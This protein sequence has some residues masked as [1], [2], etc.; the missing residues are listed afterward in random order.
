MKAIDYLVNEHEEIILFTDRLEEEC[1]K[2]MEDKLIDEKFFRAAIRYIREF[3][4]GVHHK[5]EED[6]LFKYMVESL[7]PAAEKLV[8]NGMLVEHQMARAYCMELEK[9][10]ESYL[11]SKDNRDLLQVITNTMSYVNLLRQHADK[12][13]KVVYPFAQ[14]HLSNEIKDKIEIESFDLVEI[15]K[16]LMPMKEELKKIIFS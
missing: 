3:A 15:E 9:S 2:I 14:K 16:R 5:K 1:L 12:E 10:L 7:G 6:I 13:N 11:K 8:K 4:D